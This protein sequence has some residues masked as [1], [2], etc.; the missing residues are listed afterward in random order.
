M[1][2]GTRQHDYIRNVA[3]L[4]AAPFIKSDKKQNCRKYNTCRGNNKPSFEIGMIF[5]EHP[6]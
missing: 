5:S 1:R 4:P 2:R 3:R 6:E